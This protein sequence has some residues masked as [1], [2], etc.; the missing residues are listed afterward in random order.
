[1]AYGDGS[2]YKNNRGQWVATL[3]AGWTPSGKRRRLVRKAATKAAAN[4]QLAKMRTQVAREGIPEVS[5]EWAVKKY[6]DEWLARK[7]GELRPQA[8]RAVEYPIRK[9]IVPSIGKRKLSTLSAHDVRRI[10]ATVRDATSTSTARTAHRTLRNLLNSAVADG[11]HVPKSALAVRSPKVA[12][13]D[14][15]SMSLEEA[16]RCLAVAAQLP[17]GT[18]WVLPLLYG[19]RK[20][21]CL[22]ATWE[23]FDFE[24]GTFTLAWK[25]EALPYNVARDRSSGFRVP[26]GFESRHLVDAWHLTRPKTAT[27]ER[28]L[29]LIGPLADALQEWKSVAPDNPW[30]LVWPTAHGRPANPKAD[31]EEWRAIQATAGV[32]HPTSPRAYHV[33]EC[34]N[35]AATQLGESGAGSH[36]ITSVLGHSDVAQSLAYMRAERDAT[37]AVLD[38]IGG[39]LLEGWG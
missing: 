1:M 17:H 18:R 15:T 4:K 32:S 30:G 8:Y 23:E 22:G 5:A 19:L 39:R 12:A 33:H 28:A 36:I 14:R 10:Q 35:F 2:I 31:S 24:A 38:G 13:S 16:L 27:T 21:E 29:P 34:R 11:H 37:S 26:D 6:A 7:S 3:E 25:L 9:Y 20:G